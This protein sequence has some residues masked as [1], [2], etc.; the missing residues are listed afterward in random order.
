MM[1]RFLSNCKRVLRV[2]RKPS[3]DEYLQIAK[4]TGIG[5]LLVGLIGFIIMFLG[6]LLIGP[7][8]L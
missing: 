1:G 2:A 4:V 3:K 5:I 7:R 6:Y 8:G